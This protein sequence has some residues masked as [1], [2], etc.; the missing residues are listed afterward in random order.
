MS[1]GNYLHT[2]VFSEAATFPDN[3]ILDYSLLFEMREFH[4]PSNQFV[5]LRPVLGHGGNEFAQHYVLWRI[6]VRL[7]YLRQK[8]TP[9]HLP[10][11]FLPDQI[12]P[13]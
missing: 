1:S 5:P 6:R 7:L 8:I 10:Q 12:L 3:T 11:L 4:R 9:Y 2:Q 13:S